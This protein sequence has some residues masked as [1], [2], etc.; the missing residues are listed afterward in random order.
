MWIFFSFLAPFFHSIANIL[1]SNLSNK[2][3]KSKSTLLFYSSLF[4]LVFLPIVFLFVGLPDVPNFKT[5]LIYIVIALVN[6]SSL[7][8]YYKA[9]EKSDTSVVISLFSLDK[10]FLPVF[11]FLIVGEVLLP[12]QYLGV[13]IVVLASTLVGIEKGERFKFNQAFWLMFGCAFIVS[14]EAVL[15]KYVFITEDWITGFA[16]P[17]IMTFLLIFPILFFRRQRKDIIESKPSFMKSLPLFASE[18]F[19]TFL[20]SAVGTYAVSIASVTLV[21]VIGEAQALFVLL[22]AW[23]LSRFLPGVFKEKIDG[24]SV[25]R[26]TLLFLLMIG[27][28]IL[29]LQ[30]EF[31]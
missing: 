14:I 10:L 24:D 9:L 12:I 11:A 27:G 2:L 31:F 16:W 3:F 29:T 13:F 1:D 20:G 8:L 23:L 6:I 15:Y 19:V 30:G 5:F 7:Y 26:K 22:E 25:V 4:N 28:I 17:E 21:G 18:E